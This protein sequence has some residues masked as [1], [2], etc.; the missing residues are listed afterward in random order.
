[1]RVLTIVHQP[2]AGPGV[3]EAVLAGSAHDVEHWRPDLTS[4]PAAGA[5]EYDAT[6]VFGGAMNVDQED[7]HPW[8]RPEKEFL[9]ELHARGA[10]VL[11]VCLGAQLLAEAADGAARPAATR[12]VG[13]RE[14]RLETAAAADP[15][16]GLVPRRFAAFQWHAYEI[17]PPVGATVLARSDCCLQ[18]FRTGK[19]A[20][21]VQFHAEVTAA[22]VAEWMAKDAE[23]G[24]NGE[25][26]A[27]GLE[28]EA[29]EAETTRRA[30]ASGRLGASLCRRFLA[31][32]QRAAC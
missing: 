9:S 28:P 10:P 23:A 17:E 18:A 22:S 20:W 25:L 12:E 30:R 31:L 11:G 29:L 8:L 16:L 5:A 7:E 26:R 2:D 24:A 13:W 32:A 4:G 3:F 6:L 27:A 21:G 15:L 19:R 14:V 1:V